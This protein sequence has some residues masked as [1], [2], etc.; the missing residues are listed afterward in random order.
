MA[1][2]KKTPPSEPTIN[3]TAQF[4]VKTPF[5]SLLTVAKDDDILDMAVN[6]VV[7]RHGKEKAQELFAKSLERFVDGYPGYIEAMRQEGRLPR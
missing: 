6:V 2:K 7:Q 4:R 5:S 3:V 1:S